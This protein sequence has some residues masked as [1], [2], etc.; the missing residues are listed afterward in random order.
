M[1]MRKNEQKSV[2]NDL[3]KKNLK[4]KLAQ[5]KFKRSFIILHERAKTVR[6]FNNYGDQWLDM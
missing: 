6:P 1:V 2:L 4:Q 3:V 5:Q